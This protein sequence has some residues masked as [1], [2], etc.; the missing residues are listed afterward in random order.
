MKANDFYSIH[1]QR[2]RQNILN[3]PNG[4]KIFDFKMPAKSDFVNK[5]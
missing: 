3:R 2:R 5:L 1:V 4:L